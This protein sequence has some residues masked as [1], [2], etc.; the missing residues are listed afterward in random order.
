MGGN[1]I[2]TS[3]GVGQG[4]TFVLDVP[5]GTLTASEELFARKKVA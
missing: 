2:A 4:A 1:L 3:D 5:L